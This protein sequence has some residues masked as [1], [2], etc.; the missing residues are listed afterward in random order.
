MQDM[1]FN[2][3]GSIKVTFSVPFKDKGAAI[4]LS[5]MFGMTVQIDCH[6]VLRRS[7]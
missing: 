5:D 2:S 3:D 4:P 6:R 7:A 1:R